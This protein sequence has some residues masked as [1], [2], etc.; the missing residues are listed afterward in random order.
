MLTYFLTTNNYK[1]VSAT[2]GFDSQVDLQNKSIPVDGNLNVTFTPILSANADF[3]SNNYS[4]LNLTKRVNLKEITDINIPENKKQ[5]LFGLISVSDVD[6]ISRYLAFS[7][8]RDDVLTGA[9][10]YD[11]TMFSSVTG[12]TDLNF[13]EIDFVTPTYC[14][15]AHLYKNNLYY[16]AF[17]PAKTANDALNLNFVILSAFTPANEYTRRFAYLYD[18]INNLLTLQFRTLGD[19]YIVYRNNNRLDLALVTSSTIFNNIS[20]TAIFNVSAFRFIDLPEITVEWGSYTRALNQNNIDL[21][22]NRSVTNL[23]NNFLLNQEYYNLNSKDYSLPVNILTLKNQLNITNNQGRGNVF[24]DKPEVDYRTYQTLAAGG[25]QERGY[26]NL[27]LNYNSYSTPYIFPAGKTTWFHTPQDMYPYKKLNVAATSLIKSGAVAGDHPLRS[28]KIFKKLANYKKTSNQGNSTGEQTGQWLCTWL[29]AGPTLQSMPVWVDRFYTPDTTTPYQA[30]NAAASDVTYVTTYDCLNL[31]TGIYDAPSSLTFEPGCWYAYSHIGTTDIKKIIEGLK[32]YLQ[33]ADFDTYENTDGTSL[34]PIED[35][36]GS[37]TYSFDGNNFA[38]FSVSDINLPVNTFTITFWA[39]S[40]NWLQPKGYELGGNFN[41]YGFGIYN[42]HFVT[43]IIFYLKQGKLLALNRDLEELTTF[44]TSLSTFGNIERIFRRDPLN[45]FHVLTDQQIILEYDIKE[46]LVDAT[47]QLSGVKGLPIYTMNDESRGIMLYAD[48]TYKAINLFSN[49]QETVSSLKVIGDSS[50]IKE[51]TKFNNGQIAQIAGTQTQIFGN[52]AYFLSAGSIQ[53]YNTQ[54]EVLTS[55][56]TNKTNFACFCIDK[57]SNTWAASGNQINIYNN[58]GI[59]TKTIF[60]T[61]DVS[62]ST[63]PLKIQNITFL[64]NFIAGELITDTLISASGSKEGYTVAYRLNNRYLVEKSKLIQTD[65]DLLINPDPSNHKFNYSYIRNRYTPESY[66]FKIRLYNPL[67]T[68]D[69]EIPQITVQATDLNRGSHHFAIVC[70]S[71]QGTLTVYVDKQ[72]YGQASF[73]PQKY[74]FTPLITNR[75]FA[76]ATTFYGG[77]LLA[78][79][80]DKNKVVKS[81]YFCKGFDV[82]RLYFYNRALDYYDVAMHY[83]E[84]ISPKTLTWDVPSGRR[85]FTESISR[86]F[87]QKIPG[88]KSGLFNLWINS[89]LLSDQS[90]QI[91]EVAIAEKIKNLTPAYSRLNSINWYSNNSAISG[92]YVFSY[93]PN[94]TLTDGAPV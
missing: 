75:V 16:L 29:S 80:L 3:A 81:S 37:L 89:N 23:R 6:N 82:Q 39:D 58:I 84:K 18:D 72:L 45:T 44:D 42:Y 30:I 25:N 54:T 34:F 60:L 88:A 40:N 8:E 70:D 79:Y 38:S 59:L 24:I 65:R 51:I 17:D 19:S 68:E 43:P 55:F 57:F 46:T 52:N 56:L 12:I 85:N 33:Q 71:T 4:F 53:Y 10:Y 11:Q 49:L 66:T 13:F 77:L 76:G 20:S 9:L 67:N 86:F 50:E 90:K 36:A 87:K 1:P 69:L 63:T 28:D 7:D 22:W 27:H 64:E 94:N 91:L 48:N 35:S 31:P 83:G 26:T 47:S 15:V 93:L 2:Y 92:Q 21:D 41:D 32:I 14:T 62:I 78:D 61:A 74:N 73:T 5:P